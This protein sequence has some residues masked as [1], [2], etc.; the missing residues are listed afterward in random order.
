MK[1][2]LLNV[3]LLLSLTVPAQANSDTNIAVNHAGL[4]RV[5][6][7]HLFRSV[8]GWRPI[9]SDTLIV[10]TT[11]SKPYLIELSRKSYD[12][13][14]VEAIGVTSTAGDIYEKFDDIV[15]DGSPYPIQAIY[16]LDRKTARLMKWSS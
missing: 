13:R 6:R 3:A 16:K 15:V 7:I 1:L 12:L 14:F 9:D 8:D 5:D 4:E 10:W 11:P 2:F